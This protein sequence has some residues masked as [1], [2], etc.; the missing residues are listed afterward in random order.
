MSVIIQDY[1]YK[2]P[3]QMIGEE[4]GVCYGSDTTD[5]NKNYKRGI[6][7]LKS[8]HGRTWEFPDVYMVLDEYS[9]RVVRELYTHIGGLPTRLQSSTRYINYQD[10]FEYFTPPSIETNSFAKEKYDNMM[11]FIST[12]L[13]E[14]EDMGIPRED[15]ANGLPLGMMT[16]VVCKYNFR[17]LVDMSHQ[18]ECT[19]AYHEFRKLFRDICIALSEYS[20]EW[21]YLVDNYFM[22]ECEIYGYCPEKKGCGRK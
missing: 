21:K 2:Y 19:R 22:P 11:K 13:K 6:D 14:L 4:A 16:K 18:R 12:T 8:M 17:T 5:K 10:G 1:T 7:C 20:D 15:S 3:I 9:A